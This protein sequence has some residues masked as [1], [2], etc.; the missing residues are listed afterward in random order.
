VFVLLI[1]SANVAG[2]LLA[3][4]AAQQKELAVRA[5][6]GSTRFRIVRQLLT[7][8]HFARNSWRAAWS[9]GWLGRASRNSDDGA[10]QGR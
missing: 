6:L 5:A 3:R 9:R 10:A 8:N 7:G 4:G 2:L 1:A